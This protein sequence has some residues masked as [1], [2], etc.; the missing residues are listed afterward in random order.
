MGIC[1]GQ[2]KPVSA[3]R[4]NNAGVLEGMTDGRLP[5]KMLAAHG[6][7]QRK[8]LGYRPVSGRRPPSAAATR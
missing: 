3:E 5:P 7:E 1:A 6:Q 4:V 8:C 2:F